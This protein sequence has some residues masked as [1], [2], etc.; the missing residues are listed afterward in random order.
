VHSTDSSG[1]SNGLS[2]F[3][4]DADKANTEADK[5]HQAELKKKAEGAEACAKAREHVSD[6]EEK[7]P[8]HLFVAGKDSNSEPSR[9]TEEEFN[10][11]LSDAQKAVSD[12]CH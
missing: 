4:N 1:L 5:A 2:K 10:K 3:V 12:N 9:M 6:L 7:G 8:H 11:Q